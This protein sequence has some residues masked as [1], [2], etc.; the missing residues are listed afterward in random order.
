M[1]RG[2]SRHIIIR[3]ELLPYFRTWHASIVEFGAE[4]E[5]F[6]GVYR[7]PEEP[8][9][10]LPAK[11]W[12]WIL[13]VYDAH[14]FHC[15]VKGVDPLTTAIQNSVGVIDDVFSL[16]ECYAMIYVLHFYD[17]PLM[18]RALMSAVVVRLQDF[19]FGELK[20]EHTDVPFDATYC[21][22]TYTEQ[23]GREYAEWYNAVQQILGHYLNNIQELCS[24][25]LRFLP[26]PTTNRSLIAMSDNHTLMI[27]KKGL[28]GSGSNEFGQLGIPLFKSEYGRRHNDNVYYSEKKIDDV[29]TVCS[30]AAGTNHSIVLARD[31]VYATGFNEHGQ[32]GLGNTRDRSSFEKIALRHVISV[33]CG[34][35]FTMMITVDNILFGCGDNEAGQLGIP[36][37][38]WGPLAHS[39]PHKVNVPHPVVAVACGLHH[40]MAIT[41]NGL[42]GWG[43]T[44]AL[45]LGTNDTH[46]PIT[47][48]PL[49]ENI[50]AVACNQYYSMLLDGDGSV[51]MC[52]LMPHNDLIYGVPHK[53]KNQPAVHRISCCR[54]F[55]MMVTHDERLFMIGGNSYVGGL[56][57]HDQIA[58]D[59]ELENIYAVDGSTAVKVLE[60][61]CGGGNALIIVRDGI[62]AWGDNSSGTLM[63]GS[64]GYL[65]EPEKLGHL[66]MGHE[67]YALSSSCTSKNKRKVTDEED[68][69]EKRPRFARCAL[70]T[71]DAIY[72]HPRYAKILFCGQSC[73][74]RYSNFAMY[75]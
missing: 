73:Y 40:A 54:D 33:A 61:H 3:A 41:T 32:L 38:T 69:V 60:A 49:A 29:D 68:A 59:T 9:F 74:E 28:Y 56:N 39:T 6:H 67:K 36:R 43:Y 65:E 15:A 52:G 50:T 19:S 12:H 44:R 53:V 57:R 8:R 14:S 51:F 26:S 70:C 18:L 17:S 58:Y 22:A 75:K 71:N 55:A 23:I 48:I 24:E 21:P 4:V 16:K 64:T 5:V 63:Q 47:H 46:V 11:S 30:V 72:K 42:Y 35:E 27:N 66:V 25:M 13:L 20:S 1:E 45:G 7:I 10:H 2:D 34:H 37:S 62:M 31:G